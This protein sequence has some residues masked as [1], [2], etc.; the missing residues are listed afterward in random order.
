M[1]PGSKIN[2][3]KIEKLKNP[4]KFKRQLKA[5]RKRQFGVK[6]ADVQ[7]KEIMPASHLLKRRTC[8][9]ANITLSGKKKRKILKQLRRS[10]KEKEGMEFEVLKPQPKQRKTKSDVEMKTADIPQDT[11]QDPEQDVEMVE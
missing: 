3:P 5:Q 11:R 7:D 6:M 10:Q 9:K 2:R 1:A 8:P 4:R